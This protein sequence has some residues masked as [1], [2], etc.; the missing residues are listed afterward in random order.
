MKKSCLFFVLITILVFSL[1]CIIWLFPTFIPA[2][3]KCVDFKLEQLF[4]TETEISPFYK[5]KYGPLVNNIQYGEFLSCDTLS[6]VSQSTSETGYLHQYIIG[7]RN[8]LTA[9]Y[10][11]K[12]I[13][14][15]HKFDRELIEK[16]SYI[17]PNADVWWRMCENTTNGFYCAILSRYDEIIVVTT[18]SNDDKLSGSELDKLLEIF[19][20]KS[21]ELLNN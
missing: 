21:N 13:F 2:A 3:E 18:F 7:F 17:S 9:I 5:Y 10:S 14:D 4:Y 6:M 15:F 8:E 19:D 12:A 16:I 20:T 11:Q 1:A